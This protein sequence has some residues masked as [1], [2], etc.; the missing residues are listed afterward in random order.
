MLALFLL[1]EFL[2]KSFSFL[3]VRKK[4]EKTADGN[5]NEFEEHYG[6][7]IENDLQINDISQNGYQCNETSFNVL[8]KYLID[9]YFI[10][11]F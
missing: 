4:F 6:F 7:L 1:M 9:I 10:Y 5:R 8:G 11:N 2:L 3:A